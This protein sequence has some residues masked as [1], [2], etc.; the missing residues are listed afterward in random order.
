MGKAIDFKPKVK[1]NEP[2]DYNLTLDEIYE[3][4][5]AVINTAYEYIDSVKVLISDYEFL[6]LRKGESEFERA[7]RQLKYDTILTDGHIASLINEF[8]LKKD[9]IE[10]AKII[11]KA[12]VL[13]SKVLN[14]LN[15]DY[16]EFLKYNEEA[17]REL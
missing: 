15:S 13:Y 11:S 6:F 10:R 16:N 8:D 12:A 1:S 17:N 2:E 9:D 5:R 3:K 14:I 7:K 4:A